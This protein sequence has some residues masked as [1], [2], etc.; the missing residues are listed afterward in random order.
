MKPLFILIPSL[1]FALSAMGQQTEY[2]DSVFTN[3]VNGKLIKTIKHYW[4]NG[5]IK[6]GRN[7]CQSVN[8]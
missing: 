8:L 5:S 2:P 1:L 4:E 6:R 7:I 3:K